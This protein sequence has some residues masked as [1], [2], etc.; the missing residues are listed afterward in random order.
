MTV[1]KRLRHWLTKGT[2]L[3]TKI[4]SVTPHNLK[5]VLPC[6]DAVISVLVDK[7]TSFAFTDNHNF[8]KSSFFKS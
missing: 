7:L 6:L 3:K 8:P 5:L 2:N 4:N 1:L